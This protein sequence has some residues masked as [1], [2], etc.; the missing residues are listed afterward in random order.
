MA[1]SLHSFCT[2]HGLPKTTVHRLLKTEGH[3]LSNGLSD[4]AIALLK[5]EYSIQ[6]EP[7]EAVLEDEPSSEPSGQLVTYSHAST[8]GFVG[9][10][11]LAGS[12]IGFNHD[13]YM[14]HKTELQQASQALAGDLNA[15][16]QAY[17]SSRVA[18]VLADIDTVAEA[19]RANAFQSMG[20]TT[21][22]ATGATAGESP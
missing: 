4:D 17:A 6:D 16:V 21:G 2:Q 20:V 9:G 3:D 13:A 10:S 15:V 19:L 12:Q 18:S 1:T 8:L 14:A 11:P 22:K 7:I 5:R